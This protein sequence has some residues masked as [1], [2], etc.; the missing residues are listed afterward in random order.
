MRRRRIGQYHRCQHWRHFQQECTAEVAIQRSPVERGWTTRL[1][2]SLPIT[3]LTHPS[4]YHILY[5]E[6]IRKT[7]KNL[8]HPY[9]RRWPLLMIINHSVRADIT[10][11]CSPRR[12]NNSRHL[13][14]FWPWCDAIGW[15]SRLLTTTTRPA[16]I[17]IYV[18]T[19][20]LTVLLS[21]TSFFSYASWTARLFR[22]FFGNYCTLLYHLGGLASLVVHIAQLLVTQRLK[23]A[24][25]GWKAINGSSSLTSIPCPMA[26]KSI[27]SS[28]VGVVSVRLK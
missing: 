19:F 8:C 6:D 11:K 13:R 20:I 4:S 18:L 16:H 9:G 17:Y 3:P 5:Q 22:I 26:L 2:S 27:C 12:K 1:E 21:S 15:R 23:C 24:F 28:G 7:L 10:R 25:I 14:S